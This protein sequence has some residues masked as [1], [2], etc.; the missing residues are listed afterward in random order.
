MFIAK[1]IA[2]RCIKHYQLQTPEGNPPMDSQVTCWGRAVQLNSSDPSSRCNSQGNRWPAP[3][4][5]AIPRGP[6]RP[7]GRFINK[8]NKEWETN[9][10]TNGQQA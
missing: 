5:D 6:G 1:W 2:S 4:H 3:S 8:R 9:G 7:G 10:E